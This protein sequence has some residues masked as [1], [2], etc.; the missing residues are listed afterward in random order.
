MMC[1]TAD[2]HGTGGAEQVFLTCYLGFVFAAQ[3]IMM[4]SS[5]TK[6]ISHKNTYYLVLFSD[7][8]VGNKLLETQIGRPADTFFQNPLNF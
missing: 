6:S 2:V 5:F 3:L 4:G 7:Q 1:R 8:N